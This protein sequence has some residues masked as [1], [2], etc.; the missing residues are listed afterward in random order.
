MIKRIILRSLQ[1][2]VLTLKVQTWLNVTD[3]FV[4]RDDVTSVVHSISYVFN[5]HLNP[6]AKQTITFLKSG[7]LVGPMFK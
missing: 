5:F 7:C 6:L 3:V 4:H 2:L 1:D